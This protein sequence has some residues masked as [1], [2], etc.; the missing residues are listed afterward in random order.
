MIESRRAFTRDVVFFA[1]L[2][3]AL[4][5]LVHGYRFGSGNQ[6][7]E[8]PIIL[9]AIDPGWLAGDF[10]TDATGGHGP[11]VYYAWLLARLASLVPL[12]GLFLG[13]TCLSSAAIV[14]SACMAARRISGGSMLA[15]TLAG[16]LVTSVSSIEL[17]GSGRLFRGDL[18]A[19]HLAT[20]VALFALW[21]G[22]TRRPVLCGTLGGAAALV[23]PAIGIEYGLLGLAASGAGLL[24]ERREREPRDEGGASAGEDRGAARDGV[25]AWLAGGSILLAVVTL[26]WW[27][28]AG[29]DSAGARWVEIESRLRHPHHALASTFPL[30]DWLLL[31]AFLAAALLCW[32]RRFHAPTADRDLMRRLLV[33]AGAA[34][35]A[36]VAGWLFTEVLPSPSWAAARLFRLA[37]VIKWIG[38]VLVGV[39]AAEWLDRRAR[40]RNPFGWLLV[41]GCGIAQPLMALIG[42][43]GGLLH[44]GLRRDRAWSR[45]TRGACLVVAA[46]LLIRHGSREEAILVM[47][48]LSFG[49]LLAGGRPTL[50]RL[51]APAAATALVVSAF[52]AARAGLPVPFVEPP[53][54]ALRDVAATPAALF[55]REAT[56]PGSVFVTPPG[57]GRFRLEA[58][59][60]IVVDFK[61]FPFGQASMEE[62][63]ERLVSLY[64][65]PSGIGFAAEEEMDRSYRRISGA[66]L[67]EAGAR[68]GAS[69][70]VLYRATPTEFPVIH[71]DAEYRIVRLPAPGLA[72]SGS[73][74]AT[75]P[76]GASLAPL[77]DP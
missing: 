58:E 7:S 2:A 27:L 35:L 45:L 22:I 16:T 36:F 14:L 46:A 8:L 68:Y 24:W 19:S 1:I 65:E 48:L 60:P 32:R 66:R 41:A 12:E 74:R 28:P 42:I 51:G 75:P 31:G 13:L 73:S 57:M 59:R 72:R 3:G 63:R 10:Y 69:F 61:A 25:G 9:R 64:G 47:V 15:A 20:A 37:G 70:A 18:T 26:A 6:I 38:L 11:R 52:L 76:E 4:S 49:L 55:A 43:F 34:L 71:E 21:A 23:H 40:A 62:W 56:P 53:A 17:G 50:T 54:I 77:P 44:E 29:G 67:V 5:P 33:P 30:R 39:V